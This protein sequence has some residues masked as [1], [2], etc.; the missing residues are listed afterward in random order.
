VGLEGG[1]QEGAS[2]VVLDLQQPRLALMSI[3]HGE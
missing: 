3:E 1:G 2:G